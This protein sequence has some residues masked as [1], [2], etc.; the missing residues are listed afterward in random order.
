MRSRPLQVT[1]AAILVALISLMNFPGPWWYLVPGA[2]EATPMFVIYSGIVLGIVGLVAAVGL[3]MLKTWG[4]W[5]TIVVSVVN[6]L[7]NVFGL[8][9]VPTVALQVVIA[10]QTIGFVLT[11]VVVV[12]PDSRRAFRSFPSFR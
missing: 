11:I 12:L 1:V 6:I 4:L 8:A 10:V 5:L 7:F 3:W 9:M 2:V